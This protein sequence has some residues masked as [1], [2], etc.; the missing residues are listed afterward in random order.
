MCSDV[1]R[2]PIKDCQSLQAA[3]AIHKCSDTSVALAGGLLSRLCVLE[4]IPG[5][6]TDSLKW[7]G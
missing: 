4:I 7:H 2:L 5:Y 6:I 1:L 3:L